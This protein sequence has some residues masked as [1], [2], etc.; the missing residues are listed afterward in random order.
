MIWA[1]DDG[2]NVPED[3][4]LQ[5]ALC[6]T[7]S[8][9]SSINNDYSSTTIL[10]SCS[11]GK[12]TQY[13]ITM[14]LMA[15]GVS[16]SVISGSDLVWAIFSDRGGLP[17]HFLERLLVDTT[18][19]HGVIGDAFTLAKIDFMDATGWWP[20]G[21]VLTHFCDPATKQLGRVTSIETYEQTT[22]TPLF[23]VYPNPTSRSV[24]IY[25][26]PSASSEIELDVFDNS[27]RLVQTVFSGM[28]AGSRTLTTELPT[29]I[30][31][32]RYRNDQRTQ[33]KK[34]VVVNNK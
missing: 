30:Y 14:E 26:Q 4:E 12:P 5:H 1:W 10:R 25:L 32:V 29:G 19:T 2:D 24:T 13:N 33:F 11:C 9:V 18:V 23:A 20:N 34:V 7:L 16:S 3:A 15:E 31:F 8:D 22:P 27:G 17:H 21:Y 6:L 28:V